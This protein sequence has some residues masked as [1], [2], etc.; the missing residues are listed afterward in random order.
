MP[1]ISA[2]SSGLYVNNYLPDMEEQRRI[3][4]QKH[5]KHAILENKNKKKNKVE[6]LKN[7]TRTRSNCFLFFFFFVLL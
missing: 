6:R 3:A 7:K 1:S 4:N 5:E 2:L